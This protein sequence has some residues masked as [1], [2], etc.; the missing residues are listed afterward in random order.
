MSYGSRLTIACQYQS[1]STQLAIG[2]TS[3]LLAFKC[4]P[5]SEAMII[6]LQQS[7]HCFSRLTNA[8]A[9]KS[10]ASEVSSR[11]LQLEKELQEMLAQQVNKK[12]KDSALSLV[13]C[14][15]SRPSEIT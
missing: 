15:A 10:E 3:Y 8:Q 1:A 9:V 13:P 14:V 7:I 5:K 4:L 6:T 2:I 11:K 12:D